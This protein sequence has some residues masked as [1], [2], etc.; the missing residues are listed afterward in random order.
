MKKILIFVIII[1]FVTSTLFSIENIQNENVKE[2]NVTIQVSPLTLV[3]N[4]LPYLRVYNLEIEGQYRINEI[5]N[6]SFATAFYC[7]SF[8]ANDHQ[9][10][11]K[12]MFIYRPLKTG[13]KGFYLGAYTNLGWDKSGWATSNGE[14]YITQ[15]QIGGGFNTGYK[16]IFKNG[17]TIQ[18]GVGLGKTYN[19]TDGLNADIGR[20]PLDFLDFILDFKLGYSF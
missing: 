5:F 16:W 12:P 2:N 8:G 4:I 14:V 18:L 7:I 11:F 6:I 13:L 10:V 1:V 15:F 9:F 17:F 19:S 3:T 20:I